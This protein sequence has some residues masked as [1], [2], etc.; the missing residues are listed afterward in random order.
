MTYSRVHRLVEYPDLEGTYRNR[1]VQLLALHSDSKAATPQQVLTAVAICANCVFF[2]E[3]KFLPIQE[4]SKLKASIKEN[5]RVVNFVLNN[6]SFITFYLTYA[7]PNANLSNPVKTGLQDRLGNAF[8]LKSG[9][10]LFYGKDNRLCSPGRVVMLQPYTNNCKSIEAKYISPLED[11]AAVYGFDTF[12]NGKLITGEIKYYSI[13]QSDG[14]QMDQ[15]SPDIFVISVGVNLHSTVVII[16]YVTALSFQNGCSSLHVPASVSLWQQ[17]KALNENTQQLNHELRLA[18]IG[19]RPCNDLQGCI[20]SSC[21][22]L[23]QPE[24]ETAFEKQLSNEIVILI[25]CSNSMA[26]SALHQAKPI[27]LHV[28]EFIFFRERMITLKIALK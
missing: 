6:K 2:I 22:L 21:M 23:F 17:D 19:R 26:G 20:C 28:L 5:G 18:V 9:K 13:S 14:A 24:F 27:V 12:I 4:K 7:L 1:Q 15:D 25:Y 3:L 8:P 10:C 16:T 11:K